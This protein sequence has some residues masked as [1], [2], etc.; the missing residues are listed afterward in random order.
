MR[1]ADLH[2]DG[3]GVYADQKLSDLPPG[4]TVFVGDNEAG[5]STLLAFIRGLLFGFAKDSEKEGGRPALRGGR[6]GGNAVIER[7]SGHR[8]SIARHRVKKVVGE[9][10]VHAIDGAPPADLDVLLHP[11][12][13]DVFRHVYAFSLADLHNVKAMEADQIKGALYGAAMGVGVHDLPRLLAR[14]DDGARALLTTGDKPL[15]GRLEAIEAVQGDIERH[16]AT[17]DQYDGLACTLA[18]T[19]HQMRRAD[20]R[21]RAL[22]SDVDRA[23]ANR[24]LWGPWLE[25]RGLD[26]EAGADR[27]LLDLGH[28]IEG[29][30]EACAGFGESLRDVA[31]LTAACETEAAAA[32]AAASAGTPH[33]RVSSIL[34]SAGAAFLLAGIVASLALFAVGQTGAAAAGGAALGVAGGVML[35]LAWTRRRVEGAERGDG[36]PAGRETARSLESRVDAL[37]QRVA[38]ARAHAGEVFAALGKD[39]P[40]DERLPAAVSTLVADLEGARSRR[41]RRAM[42]EEMLF[43]QTATGDRKALRARFASVTPEVLAETIARLRAEI[44]ELE[45]RLD[46]GDADGKT[47]GLRKARARLE[48]EMGR[49]GGSDALGRLRAREEVLKAELRD[50]ALQWSRQVIARQLLDESWRRYERTAQPQVIRDA[51]EWL[52]KLTD[53]RYVTIMAPPSA[54][55]GGFEAVGADHGR[56]SVEALSGGTREL[57]YMSIR[58]GYIGHQRCVAEPMPVVM[59]DILVSLDPRRA[60]NAARCIAELAGGGQVLF[61]TCHPSTVALFEKHVPDLTVVRIDDGVFVQAPAASKGKNRS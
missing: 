6:Y 49:L 35:G 24:R 55:T 8:Y 26:D 53:G 12:T 25:W 37:R 57:L 2:I 43:T 52:G 61:F 42:L 30:R 40:G 50:L 16:L 58:F 14:F 9:V 51:G 7:A 46:G 45:N 38:E 20:Q 11:L 1:F 59:D 44:A 5:K 10:R 32:M 17:V 31:A 22:R 54:D 56:R 41:A 19:V 48:V 4:L 33:A 3:F 21:L 29:L 47:E 23:E 13:R 18:D 36:E 28:P 15:Q 27:D 34:T 60:D 39:L